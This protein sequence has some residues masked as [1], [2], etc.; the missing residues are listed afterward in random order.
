MPLVR[1]RAGTPRGER[2]RN[3]QSAGYVIAAARRAECPIQ[4]GDQGERSGRHPAPEMAAVR[5][6]A[7]R[8]KEAVWLI[9][10]SRALLPSRSG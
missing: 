3:R 2:S 6:K 1:S 9:F 10:G 8:G 4:D 5:F 7:G